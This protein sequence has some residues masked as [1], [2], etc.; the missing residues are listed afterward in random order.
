VGTESQAGEM[1]PPRFPNLFII[2]AMKSG[3]SSLH[4]YLRQHPDIFMARFK[5]PQY[6]APHTTRW[7]QRWG[8]G[9]PY[10]HPGI[11]W[12]LDLFRDAGDVRYAGESSVSYTAAPWVTGCEQR[13][14]AFNPEARL[15]Y[16]MRDPVERAISHYWHFVNDGREDLTPLDAVRRKEDYVARS[17]Y[18]RQLQPYI[19]TFG[20]ERIFTLSLEELEADSS[21]WMRSLFTWL[22]VAPDVA[23]HTE[24]FNVGRTKLRQTRRHLTPIDT[25]LKHWRWKQLERMLPPAVPG[26]LRTLAYRECDRT[27]IPVADAIEYLRGVLQPKTRRLSELL[28]REFPMWKTTLQP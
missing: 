24:R 4:E 26:L 23:V 15:V 21:E 6:F 12:Y 28:G 27:A 14:H 13:I 22:G 16:I 9:Q 10:P 5:E 1:T 2:G 19:D 8:Q 3:T 18:A 25:M 20:R 11:E 7:G 17:D